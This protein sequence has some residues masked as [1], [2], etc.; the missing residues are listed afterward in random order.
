MH[1]FDPHSEEPS[2]SQR[3]REALEVFDAAEALVALSDAQLSKVPLSDELHALVLESRRITSHI[4]RK[5]Q[6]QFLA[7]QMRRRDDELPAILAALAH[8]RD[9]RRR[10][11]AATHRVEAWRDRLLAEG[12]EALGQFVEAHPTADRHHLRQLVRR[13]REERQANKAPSAARE[14]FRELRALLGGDDRIED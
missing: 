9:E 8:G 3:R 6:L 5:R 4:A 7:K 2:R 14:L 12:D 1:E 13:A 10:E 11:S